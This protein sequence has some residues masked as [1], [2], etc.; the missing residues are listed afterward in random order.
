MTIFYLDLHKKSLTPCYK[1]ARIYRIEIDYGRSEAAEHTRMRTHNPTN[2]S[3][4]KWTW[5]ASFMLPLGSDYVKC[6]LNV[7][8]MVAELNY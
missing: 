4:Q 2:I 6:D 3:C 7:M 5:V 1:A 8:L